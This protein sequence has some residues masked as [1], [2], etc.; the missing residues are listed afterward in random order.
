MGA[1]RSAFT[2]WPGRRPGLN[3]LV[4]AIILWNTVYLQRAV[5]HLRRQGIE[6]G[7]KD[8]EHLSPLGWEH[9]NL[10]DDYQWEAEESMNPDRF[11]PL[12]TRLGDLAMAA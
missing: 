3:L 1:N 11:R 10:T 5:D 12:R 6:P 2:R 4:A 9:I 8:L 7:P